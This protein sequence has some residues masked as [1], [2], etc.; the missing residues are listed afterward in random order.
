M[1][2]KRVCVLAL[3]LV[4]AGVSVASATADPTGAKNSAPITVQCG[5]TTYQGVVNGS[6]AWGPAHDLNSN[7]ILIPIAFGE[8]TVVFTDPG[9]TPHPETNPPRAKGS[10]NPRGAPLVNC[11]YHVEFSLPDGSSVVVDGTVTGF[12]TP[13]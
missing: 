3:T 9:G 10:S 4:L 1:R 13:A 5:D 12:V 7:S 2:H 11:T 8:E 6:G